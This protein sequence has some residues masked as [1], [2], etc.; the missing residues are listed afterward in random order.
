MS[1]HERSRCLR[2]AIES[3][4]PDEVNAIPLP[5]WG[6][7]PRREAR[8]ERRLLRKLTNAPP[9]FIKKLDIKIPKLLAEATASG[10]RTHTC[11]NADTRGEIHILLQALLKAVDDTVHILIDPPLDKNHDELEFSMVHLTFSMYFLWLLVYSPALDHHLERIEHHHLYTRVV[12]E[13]NGVNLDLDEEGEGIDSLNAEWPAGAQIDRQHWMG[14]DLSRRPSTVVVALM[15]W[16]RQRVA[17]IQSINVLTRFKEDIDNLARSG[18]PTPSVSI[19]CVSVDRQGGSGQMQYDWRRLVTELA[20]YPLYSGEC[21][22]DRAIQVI[23]E[24]FEHFA[25]EDSQSFKGSVHCEAYLASLMRSEDVP[26]HVRQ[27][28]EASRFFFWFLVSY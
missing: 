8:H 26:E 11:Y 10:Q 13:R 19:K 4:T 18:S 23:L 5:S 20:P 17:V 9:G 2:S 7:L 14:L 28:F 12:V 6:P 1:T 21:S 16:L 15:R 25:A 3:I 24:T 22:G 27:E